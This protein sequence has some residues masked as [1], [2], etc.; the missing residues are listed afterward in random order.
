MPAITVLVASP[1]RRTRRSCLE[2]LAEQRGV[3]VVGDAR[4]GLQT[5]AM[6]GMLK[7]RVLVLDQGLSRDNGRSLLP[8]IRQRHPG[9]RVILL[10]GADADAH[11]LDALSLGARG[12]LSWDACAT[13]LLAAVKAVD[14]GEAWVPRKMVAQLMDRLVDLY[15]VDGP[16]VSRAGGRSSA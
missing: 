16:R 2:L 5:L 8:A 15:A 14:A 12:C 4:T 13:F 10:T 9:T 3:R 11:T 7:P 6:V 1:E